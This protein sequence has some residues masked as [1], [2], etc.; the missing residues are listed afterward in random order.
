MVKILPL[1]TL[2]LCP[3]MDRMADA[4]LRARAI[5][6]VLV[7]SQDNRARIETLLSLLFGMGRVEMKLF[8][9]VG[10]VFC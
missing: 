5:E 3:S 7:P 4:R 6:I 8:I 1:G 2:E 9:M 10:E